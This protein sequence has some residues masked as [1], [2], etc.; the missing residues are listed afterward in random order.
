MT[1]EHARAGKIR[2]ERLPECVEVHLVPTLVLAFDARSRQVRPER[3]MARYTIREH[4]AAVGD[5]RAQLVEDR[6]SG[7]RDRKDVSPLRLGRLGP[8]PDERPIG[9]DVI[10]PQRSQFTEA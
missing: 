3:V 2:D 4:E 5:G 6:L 9:V 7:R 1:L 10:P 8:Q